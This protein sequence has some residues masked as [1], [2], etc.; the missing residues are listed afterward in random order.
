MEQSV[1]DSSVSILGI[2]LIAMSYIDIDAA[3]C[4]FE[5]ACSFLFH[6][7]YSDYLS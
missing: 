2:S 1:E 4:S 3:S 5:I 7:H 6:I